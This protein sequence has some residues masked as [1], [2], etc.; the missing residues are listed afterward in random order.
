MK[1]ARTQ[2]MGGKRELEVKQI[3][4]ANTGGPFVVTGK[5]YMLAM[6]LTMFWGQN[7]RD[8]TTQLVMRL[9]YS[10]NELK[11]LLFYPK[12]QEK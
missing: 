11:K 8:K 4:A 12:P 1:A 6:Y 3:L 10:D 5:T 9:T 7:F 2:E